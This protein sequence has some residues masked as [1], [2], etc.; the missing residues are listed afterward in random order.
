MKLGIL[1]TFYILFLFH[2]NETFSQTKN[3]PLK[4]ISNYNWINNE[5]E[6]RDSSLRTINENKQ[7]LEYVI[8]NTKRNYELDYDEKISY[9]YNENNNI[10]EIKVDMNFGNKGL[11]NYQKGIYTYNSKY[12]KI[13]CEVHQWVETEIQFKKFYDTIFQ[14][15]KKGNLI[16]IKMTD[17]FDNF[18]YHYT[19]DKKKNKTSEITKDLFDSTK[20]KEFHY[21]YDQLKNLKRKI[22]INYWRDKKAFDTS[23]IITNTFDKK[24]NIIN[25]I[26]QYLDTTIANEKHVEAKFTYNENNNYIKYQAIIDYKEVLDLEFMNKYDSKNRL[27]ETIER[28]KN[29]ETGDF[30]NSIKSNY[31]YQD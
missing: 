16:S 10:S 6:I 15:D 28:Y 8:M 26:F 31:Y 24:N 22:E 2:P 13:K 18:E 3:T 14:Y 1:L 11:Q 20:T 25:T 5:W 27:I 19:Y 29:K 30:E 4:G 7:L 23:L 9:S 17:N 12:K 21:E